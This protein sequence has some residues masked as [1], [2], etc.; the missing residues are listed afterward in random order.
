MDRLNGRVAQHLA[1]VAGGMF[2][3]DRIPK[4]LRGLVVHAGDGR[5]LNISKAPDGFRMHLAHKPSTNH[6]R[7]NFCH[8]ENILYCRCNE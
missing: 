5:D 8:I 7:S 1:V 3:A 4:R 6:R 2:D